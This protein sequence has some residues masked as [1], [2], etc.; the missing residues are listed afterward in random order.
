M[1]YFVSV[2]KSDKVSHVDAASGIGD[3]L[4]AYSALFYQA[5]I[6]SGEN[7]LITDA[8]SVSNDTMFHVFSFYL[9]FILNWATK[10]QLAP[11]SP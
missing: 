3:S 11:D 6:A 7:V 10:M 8:C 4:K 5:K 1:Q 2:K 9:R